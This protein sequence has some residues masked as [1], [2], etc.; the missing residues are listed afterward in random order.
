MKKTTIYLGAVL[1][2]F[3]SIVVITQFWNRG[4]FNKFLEIL[5]LT[6]NPNSPIETTKV[7]EN[8]N[9]ITKAFPLTINKSVKYNEAN[10]TVI[11]E[12]E[13]FDEV[14]Q[15]S[16]NIRVFQKENG[17]IIVKK[18]ANYLLLGA[19][20]LNPFASKPELSNNH[21]KI[22]Y[23]LPY[24]FELNGDVYIFDF[25]TETLQKVIQVDLEKD[26][27]AKVIKWLDEKRLLVIIGTSGGT[28]NPGGDLY[29]YN[30]LTRKLLL[31]KKTGEREQFIDINI[32]NK[33]ILLDC[34][35]WD[36]D[37]NTFTKKEVTVKT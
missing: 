8:G 4:S 23:I 29:L 12:G 13:Q 10:S 35:K 5:N 3:L 16:N 36:E 22:A 24:E 37:Y 2:L 20:A 26:Q 28:V 14:Y 32:N 30:L 27:S 34:I 18:G 19:E 25:F 9:P 15:I 31:I 21:R 1:F 33:D 11:Y 6:L 7:S 17:L